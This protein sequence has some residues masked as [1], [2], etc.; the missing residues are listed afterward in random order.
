[1]RPDS[2][3][4]SRF[5][6]LL[7]TLSF[8]LSLFSLYPVLV[9]AFFVPGT[10]WEERLEMA[11]LRVAFAA[12]ICIT[13]GLLY[14]RPSTHHGAGRAAALDHARAP[15]LL[16]AGGYGDAL[17]AFVVHRD[18]L[19]SHGQ[20]RLLPFLAPAERQTLAPAVR[21]TLA[22]D[23]VF[24][25]LEKARPGAPRRW[26]PRGKVPAGGRVRWNHRAGHR[27]SRDHSAR[28]RAGAAA[29]RC[30]GSRSTLIGSGI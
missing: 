24:A 10:Q 22:R 28:I 9:N 27:Q 17:R 2:Q 26:L 15:V 18:V 4:H 3:A 5:L 6:E 1:M 19:R 30:G 7:R 8:F 14:A 12:C 16:G 11:L 25:G 21:Q 13:S 23:S 20:P 29:I